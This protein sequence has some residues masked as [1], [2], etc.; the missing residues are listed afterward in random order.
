MDDQAALTVTIRTSEDTARPHADVAEFRAESLG[1]PRRYLGILEVASCLALSEDFVQQPEDWSFLREMSKIFANGMAYREKC[2]ARR[3]FA[4]VMVG[5]V[6]PRLTSIRFPTSGQANRG[7]FRRRAFRPAIR[8]WKRGWH[9]SKRKVGLSSKGKIEMSSDPGAWEKGIVEALSRVREPSG[10]SLM[11]SGVVIGLKGEGGKLVVTCR[12]PG[13]PEPIQ[14]RIVREIESAVQ[15]AFPQIAEV[16]VEWRAGD[17]GPPAG[18]PQLKHV[19]AVGSGKGGVGKST[20]AASLAYA[21]KHRGHSVGIMDADVYGPSIPHMLGLDGRLTVVGDKYE[22]REV[23]G[24]KV[25]SMAFLVPENQAV[26]W[27]GPMLHKAVRDFLHLV[28]WGELDYL[29]VDLPPGTG[30]VVLSLSQQMPIT[31]AVVVCTPQDVALL[32]ARKALNML[33]T[34]KIPCRG[35]VENMSFFNCPSCGA[36]SEIFGHGGAERWAK[37]VNVPFLGAV[38]INLQMR[39]NGDEGHLRDNFAADNPTR[40]NLLAIA[41][42][43]VAGI[44]ADSSPLAPTLEIV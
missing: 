21:L 38:P 27:R 28:H 20:I 5:V 29:V 19:I 8:D 9:S 44:E 2:S 14:S 18:A 3:N 33:D 16:E 13:W 31:G 40:E 22:A 7:A 36:R 10:K 35:I 30:D 12:N 42:R 17:S 24:I 6:L 4:G 43:L 26:V 23:D 37:E 41:D 32:D 11:E 34:V 25:V 39:L 1:P 15:G